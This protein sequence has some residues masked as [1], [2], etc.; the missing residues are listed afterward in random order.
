ME[1]KMKLKDSPFN[2]IKNGGSSVNL[3][4]MPNMRTG[5]KV[6]HQTFTTIVA[7]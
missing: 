1:H 4:D 2:M 6:T 3:N 7:A 5:N